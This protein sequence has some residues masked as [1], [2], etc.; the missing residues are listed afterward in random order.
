MGAAPGGGQAP[1]N[2][3]AMVASGPSSP[4]DP[5]HA[6]Y[7]P[8]TPNAL[9]ASVLAMYRNGQSSLLLRLDPPGLGTISVHVALGGNADVNVVFVPAL[10]QTAHL[11]QAGM[12]DL[13]QAMTAAGL[14][15][16]QTQIGGGGAG[17]FGGTNPG[18]QTP[19]RGA[20]APPPTIRLDPRP[21]P[22]A[23]RGAR[24]IA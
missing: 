10:P 22:G 1:A 4:G 3:G 8:A 2:I 23:R 18:D 19:H 16:G 11:L 24:A 5:A 7:T 20:P 9:A 12:G 15:L 21:Q 6:G 17:G 13:R 14:S